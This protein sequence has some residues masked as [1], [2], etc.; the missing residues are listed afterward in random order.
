[1]IS[2]VCAYENTSTLNNWLLKSLKAQTMEHELITVD[3]VGHG[4]KSA[5]QALNF[6]GNRARGKYIMFI[7]QD[8]DLVSA[9]W[10]ADAEA[11]LDTIPNL[12]IAGVV[13]SV[14]E[15]R[16]VSERMKNVIAHGDNM[17]RI[18]NPIHSP[19]RVQTLDE[20]LLIVP[21]EVFQQNQFDEN[22]CGNWHLYGADYCLTM[23][24]VGKGVYVIPLYVIHKSKGGSANKLSLIYNFGLSREYYQTLEKVLNKHKK[25][26]TWI[27]T[28]PGYG[29][30]NTT[31]SLFTQKLKYSVIEML[32]W[33][34]VRIMSFFRRK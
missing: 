34:A 23:L 24:T 27:Y 5:A 21:L 15:G 11:L 14:E 9:S 4:F 19:A 1:M 7:H 28:T 26:F 17:E 30:W 18:G 32:K 13:G 10:L 33:F 16:S 22:T 3:T 2:I 8:V 20:L 29:K 25:T 6:G 12:G 31:E